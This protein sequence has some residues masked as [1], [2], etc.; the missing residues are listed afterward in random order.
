MTL[1]TI[2]QGLANDVGLAVP[3]QVVGS[4]NRS[5]NEV[6][7]FAN[8]AGEEL[9]RRVDW[10]QL[11]ASAQLPISSSGPNAAHALP[12]GFSRL[13]PGVA[14]TNSGGEIVRPLSRAEW[15]TLT[16]VEGVPR[17][18]LLQENTVTLWP[19]LSAVD[20]VTVWYQSDAWCS[21]GTDAWSAD[22]DTSLI[23]EDL[24]LKA[25]IVRWRRQKGMEYADQEAEYEA[26]LSD[27]ARFND[28]S[29]I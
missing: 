7:S 6:L 8:A 11:S 5:M 3:G 17:Y 25:L 1:L 27:L 10:M 22:D 26:A 9:A 24:F 23:D 29:R 19:Y 12:S 28:R 4:S 13:V 2:A 20:T 18:F 21:N 14:V 16:P 15:G